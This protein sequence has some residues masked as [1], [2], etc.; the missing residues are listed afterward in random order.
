MA[1]QAETVQGFAGLSPIKQVGLLVGLAA[2]IAIGVAIALWSQRPAWSLLYGNLDETDTAQVIDALQQAAIPYRIDEHSG[3]VL[4][5]ADR[6][7]KA[8]LRLAAQGLPRGTGEG[9]ELLE[10]EPGFG[11]SQFMENVRYQHALELELARTISTLRNVREAR[12]HLAVPR[13]SVFLRRQEAPTA[14]VVVSLYAG[15]TLDDAQV[16]AIVHLVASSVPRLEPKAVTVVDQNG[17]LLSAAHGDEDVALTTTQFNYARKLERTY[18]ERIE[19]L[20]SP[21]VG[22]GKVRAQVSADIDFTR[23]EKTRETFDPDAPALRSEQVVEEDSKNGAGASGVPGTLTNVPPA[24]GVVSDKGQTVPAAGG[25]EARSSKRVIRNY[26]IDRTIS[27]TRLAAGTLRRLSI[28]V[29]VDDRQLT[30]KDGKVT[31]QPWSDQ[32]LAR[33]TDLVKK[34]VGYD[35]RRGD[36]VQVINASFQPVPEPEP[37]PDPPLWER[38]W[39]WPLVKQALAGVGVLLVLFGVIKPVMRNL[40]QSG[41]ARQ[42]AALAAAGAAGQLPPGQAGEEG[43]AGQAA[44]AGPEGEALPAPKKSYEDQLNQ[45]QALV[46]EDPRRVAQVVKTWMNEDG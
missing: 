31:H 42:E 22:E 4:V 21:L 19:R 36:T 41:A 44:L 45:A 33:F 1:I 17:R 11:V 23:V 14:S 32:D 10:K 5:P 34:A 12:V 35:P 28:A 20:L 43:Q 40:A 15:R 16:A 7:H 9:F 46:Q 13:R 24:G 30:G 39:F 25:G 37:L 26:E 3:A 27:H 38:P 6:V 29:V 2:S 18:A 8:R